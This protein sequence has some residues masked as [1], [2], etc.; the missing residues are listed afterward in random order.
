MACRGGS[1]LDQLLPLC[2]Q[3]DVDLPT[4]IGGGSVQEQGEP[5]KS[6]GSNPEGPSDTRHYDPRH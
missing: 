3:E 6:K 1:K 2:L 5:T 4:D